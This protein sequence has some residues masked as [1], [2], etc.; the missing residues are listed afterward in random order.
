MD[1]SW[2][3][4]RAVGDLKKNKVKFLI[5]SGSLPM[6]VITHLW[7]YPS[8]RWEAKSVLVSKC[9][10][11][12]VKVP[13]YSERE[14]TSDTQLSG[15]Y[16]QILDLLNWEPLKFDFLNKIIEILP[17]NSE[18]KSTLKVIKPN[19]LSSFYYIINFFIKDTI[20]VLWLPRFLSQQQTQN[21][22]SLNFA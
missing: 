12:P 3:I 1:E 15:F 9:F 4:D 18:K 13:V 16:L 5:S 2:K 8:P 22:I 17:W 11:F 7:P 21:K 10:G 6:K 14:N 19:F 20:H